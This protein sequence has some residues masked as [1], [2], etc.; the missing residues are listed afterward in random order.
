MSASYLTKNT[1][2]IEWFTD[3]LAEEEA[4][5]TETPVEA[6]SGESEVTFPSAMGGVALM[7]TDNADNDSIQAQHAAGFMIGAVGPVVFDTRVKLTAGALSDF[8]VGLVETDTTVLAGF[9]NGILI[10][11]VEATENLLVVKFADGGS[12]ETFTTGIKLD[13]DTWHKLRLEIYPTTVAN[14]AHF[15]LFLDDAGHGDKNSARF[16]EG[17]TTKLEQATL[18]RPTMALAAREAAAKTA[19]VDLMRVNA[20]R[21]D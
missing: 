12:A 11:C 17:T 16:H 19:Y 20:P 8:G 4:K 1:D 13:D 15:K 14:K 18:F 9:N 10:Y 6:G 7:T 2:R 5:W 21:P 3:F